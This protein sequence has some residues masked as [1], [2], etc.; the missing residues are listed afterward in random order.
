MDLSTDKLSFQI[1]TFGQLDLIDDFDDT[2]Q[3]SCFPVKIEPSG[4]ID[5]FD[6]TALESVSSAFD[7]AEASPF[8]MGAGRAE[9]V[10]VILP[11]AKFVDSDEGT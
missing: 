4:G 8:G 3:C 1:C 9:S 2:V 5:A 11:A 6:E 7:E 10:D